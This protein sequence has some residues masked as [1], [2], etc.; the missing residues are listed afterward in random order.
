MPLRIILRVIPRDLIKFFSAILQPRNRTVEFTY[1]VSADKYARKIREYLSCSALST[2]SIHSNA[3]S[4][5][6][7][8]ISQMC[9]YLAHRVEF[10]SNQSQIEKYCSFSETQHRLFA[11]MQCRL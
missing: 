4:T 10:P 3:S 7:A 5:L 2:I 1:I 11:V 6:D 8:M 9:T